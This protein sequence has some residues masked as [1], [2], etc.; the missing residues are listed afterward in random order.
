MKCK[1]DDC[2][3]RHGQRCIKRSLMINKRFINAWGCDNYKCRFE[4]LFEE[5]EI[6]NSDSNNNQK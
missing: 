2:I 1:C 6:T 5:K 3:H 4:S